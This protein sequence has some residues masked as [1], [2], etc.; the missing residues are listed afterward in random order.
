MAKDSKASLAVKNII[1]GFGGKFIILILGI[2]IP[3]IL[4]VSF[5]SELNGFLSTITQIFTYFALLEA[6]IGNSAVN[7]LYG[8]LEKK[9]YK[10]VNMA[11]TQARTYYRKATTVY[12]IVVLVFAFVY[13][14]LMPSGMDK[15]LMIK[16]I[17]LQG[18]PHAI[19]YYFCAVYNQLLTA[20]G[21]RYVSENMQLVFHILTSAS[22]IILIMCGFDIIAVQLAFFLIMLAK[23]PILV[24][25][26]KKKYPW[27]SFNEES[28]EK[29]LKERSAF[30]V[31]EVSSTIFS[32]TDVFVISV[33]C[34]FEAASVYTVYNMIFSSLNSL[35]NTANVGLGFV[36]GRNLDK[37]QE[38]FRKIF[39]MYSTMYTF[40]IFVVMTTATVLSIPFVT[41]YTRGISDA[42]YILKWIPVLFGLINV[43][44]GARAIPARLISVSGHAEK[45]KNRS[46]IEMLLNISVSVVLAY[47]LDLY[48]V[49]LGTIVAL[50]YRMNDIIFYAD[51]KILNRSPKKAYAFLGLCLSIFAYAVYVANNIA[52]N[53]N[54]YVAMCLYGAVCFVILFVVFLIPVVIVEKDGVMFVYK[55]LKNKSSKVFK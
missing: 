14:F 20:D 33:F 46:V 1:Y 22:K 52:W 48:G 13:P 5:G 35:V 18:A 31:H 6:G 43:M 9:D 15:G 17:L 54:S 4:I 30:V 45:T 51:K 3:R 23:I 7:A 36:L 16:V 26:C 39:D 28:D 29:L 41:L 32:N 53:V 47:Y 34:G 25:Y 8:P 10:R 27:L 24:I 44:S 49:L 2:I 21:K 11:A 19:S 55:Y 50:L 42:N 12:I 37:P 38:K 40:V